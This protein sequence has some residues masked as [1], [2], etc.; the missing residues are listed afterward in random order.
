MNS[1]QSC[2]N[3]STFA[4]AD[5]ESASTILAT[6]NPS[7]VPI[8][9]PTLEPTMMETP[10]AGP[11]T[12]PADSDASS[13]GVSIGSMHSH[14]I[15]SHVRASGGHEYHCQPSS[16]LV[17]RRCNYR[18]WCGSLV[19]GSYWAIVVEAAPA[20]RRQRHGLW[21]YVIKNFEPVIAVE[22]HSGL[23]CQHP[24]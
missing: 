6:R 19:C 21:D 23:Y 8:L 17:M 24:E 18:L 12:K 1:I 13:T 15:H 5:V 7:S 14:Q 20:A 22:C 10:T 4:G 2:T 11:S 16:Q 3:S 9:T